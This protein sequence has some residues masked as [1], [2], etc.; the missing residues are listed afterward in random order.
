V[1]CKQKVTCIPR[2]IVDG[3]YEFIQLGA[4]RCAQI[5]RLL[6]TSGHINVHVGRHGGYRV[7]FVVVMT[8]I[9]NSCTNGWG[10]L[11]SENGGVSKVDVIFCGERLAL[12]MSSKY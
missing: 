9:A 6:I 4:F 5:P 8:W 7:W 10:L 11:T 12:S 1:T 3:I 2:R